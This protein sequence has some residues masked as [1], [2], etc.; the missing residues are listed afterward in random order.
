MLDCEELLE[1]IEDDFSKILLEKLEGRKKAI[2][3]PSNLA[4]QAAL[5]MDPR[6]NNNECDLLSDSLKKDI[7]GF[8][9]VLHKRILKLKDEGA[10]E[11]DSDNGAV[12]RPVLKAGWRKRLPKVKNPPP[13]AKAVKSLRWKLSQLQ[14]MDPPADDIDVLAYWKGKMA[15]DKELAELALVV[16]SLPASQVSVERAFSLLPLI[17]TKMRTKTGDEMLEELLFVRLNQTFL[18]LLN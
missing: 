5:F 3:D 14:Y 1:V 13:Q 12:E 10:S 6:I 16:L 9:E 8:L 15:T 7:I 2:M 11:N 4:S 17:F 18:E